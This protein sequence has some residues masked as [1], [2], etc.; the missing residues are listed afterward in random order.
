MAINA[1]D[2]NALAKEIYSDKGVLNL[3]PD[4]IILAKDY[5]FKSAASTG[6]YFVQPV[7]MTHESGFTYAN[8]N[9]AFALNDAV[10]AIFKDAQVD[11]AAV[12]LKSALSY[13]QMARLD[14]SKKAFAQAPATLIEDMNQA[15]WKRL[16]IAM[17]YGRSAGG[18]A[19]LGTVGAEDGNHVVN[20]PITPATFAPGIWAGSEG[21]LVDLI[22]S[23][24]KVNSHDMSIKA[25]TISAT[26]PSID[27]QMNASESATPTAGDV[28][29][30]KGALGVEPV[31]LDRIVTNTG[32]LFN[33][34]AAVYSLWKAN[35]VAVSAAISLDKILEV[36][37]SAVSKG[38]KGDVNVYICAT[39]FRILSAT[40]AGLRRFNS[41]ED[42]KNAVKG[43]E[44]ISFFHQTGKLFIKPSLHV[45]Q[46][47]MFVVPVEGG[48]RIG[49]SDVTFN[50]PGME[51]EKL[52]HQLESN[53]GVGLRAFTHQGL[54]FE[55]P[56]HLAKGTGIS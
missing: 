36:V 53:A 54:F 33:I 26:A 43:S 45:K 47:D 19:T 34:D 32:S 42:N 37:D 8:D 6:D 9:T 10:P 30:W 16:E 39:K 1:T 24:S 20:A 21:S 15:M 51:G 50:T 35:T 44:S 55:K 4:G 52:F 11:G 27:I 7:K 23:G 2:L 13:L 46:A 40:D 18:L 14:N 17:F 22:R 48:Y 56:A 29:V 3:I 28:L 41:S 31:G 49:A 5:K 38:L 12:V 25:V